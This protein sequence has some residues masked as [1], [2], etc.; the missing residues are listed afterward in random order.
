V[1]TSIIKQR[2]DNT[3]TTD[4][5]DFSDDEKTAIRMSFESVIE[6]AKESIEI[7][8][9]SASDVNPDGDAESIAVARSGLID[10]NVREI[11]RELKDVD[12]LLGYPIGV[13]VPV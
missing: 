1:Q 5:L 10:S 8:T 7:L 3:M 6:R 9:A 2:G 12:N 11:I 13:I 4:S